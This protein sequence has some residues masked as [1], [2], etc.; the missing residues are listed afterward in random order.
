MF[1][2]AVF[3]M[4][5]ASALAVPAP[6]GSSMEP[7]KLDCLE[8]E[9]SIFSC[10]AVKTA[11][12][13]DRASRSKDIQI[14]DGVTFVREAPL[15]RNGKSLKTETEVM[16]ELPRDASDRTLKLASMIYESALAFLKSHSLKL[17]VP[18]GSI[19]R[20]LV[21]GRGKIKKM[22]LPL[23][24]AAGVKIF[25]LVPIVLG[26]L[27]LLTLKALF[28]GKIALL[29]A[30]ILAFQKLFGSGAAASG[31]AIFG[32]PAQPVGSWI[33]SPAGQGWA[34]NSASPQSSGY[35]RRS[36]DDADIK[37]HAQSL[38]Y[39]AQIPPGSE[40]N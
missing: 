24:A 27:A 16:N 13:L 12:V 2:L 17:N 38:A 4:L 31:G 14:L 15:E 9:N 7:G 20:A 3:G 10:I 6:E 34:A 8:Q 26:G 19:S 5:L 39:N 18:E 40:A 37:A 11:V 25:A 33:E 1:R 30:G 28:V 21:E 22:I 29:I 36:F 23:V 35:Y 32:K